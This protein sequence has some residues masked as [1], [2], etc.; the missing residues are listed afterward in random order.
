MRLN[1]KEFNKF[2]KFNGVSPRVLLTRLGAGDGAYRK[3]KRRCPLGYELA[4]DIYNTFGEELFIQFVI[5][6][7]ESLDGFKSKY[8]LVGDKLC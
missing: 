3:L 2:E 6:E 1:I 5:M 4:R 7:E 8:I